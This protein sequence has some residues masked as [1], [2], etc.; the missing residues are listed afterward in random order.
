[1]LLAAGCREA[2]PPV[3]E[4]GTHSGGRSVE[5]YDIEGGAPL[6]AV[7]QSGL[8]KADA[9]LGA[10]LGIPAADRACG[11]LDLSGPRLALV[12]PDAMFYGASVP[13]LCILLGYFET[14]PEAAESL[15]PE[16]ERE[17]G[18]MIKRSSNE[19]AAK[20]SQLIGLERLQAIVQ[21][22]RHRL[23]DPER[24]GGL[25]CGKHYG[26][27]APRRGDPLR[28][29]SHAATVRQCLRFYLLLEQGRLVNPAA[30]RR[31]RE[32]F[33]SPLL[34]FHDD[35]FVAGL[36]GRDVAVLRKNGLWE[37][38]HLDTARVEHAGRVYLLAAMA[39]HPRG[40]EY[41]ARLA[42]A[43]DDLVCG[44]APPAPLRH[45]LILHESAV[46]VS[47]EFE[48]HVVEPCTPFNEV[49]VSWNAEVPRGA[50]MAVDLR[51]GR[52]C[53]G[54]WSPYLRIGGWGE[55]APRLAIEAE[56]ETEGKNPWEGGSI[57]V[58]YFRSKDAARYDRLQYRVRAWRTP[59]DSAAQESAQVR[60]VRVALST[61]DT[62]GIPLSFRP[63][64][65]E[66]AEPPPGAWQRRLEVPFR[67]QRAEDAKLAARICSPTS[68]AMVMAYRGVVRSTAEVAQ[69]AY[70]AAHD[71]FGNWPRSVQAAYS[72]GVPGYLRRFA[73]WREV[74]G[75]IAAGQPL[76]ASIRA[77]EGELRG[78]PYP[79]TSGHLLVITGF[80]A[81]GNVCV[82]DP[83]ASDA[84]AGQTVYRREDIE[85]VWLRQGGTAY[86]LLAP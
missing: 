35:A 37:D 52:R 67:S 76:I 38:W 61:S 83:A 48:S 70:D 3:D 44:P 30:S 71:I 72:F 47:A 21:S 51:V 46:D 31:M 2:P 53:D 18:L 22:D 78:A 27:D 40:R 9:E 15:D 19:I 62:T 86:V 56:E 32:V 4:A 69:R 65:S 8:E 63:E 54:S 66:E 34:E 16:V 14:H 50:G 75:A 39:H 79:K 45:E 59:V 42:A 5:A 74:R 55:A 1:M 43:V 36:K 58:D 17:L 25:W 7:L 84:A 64:L 20:Y 29:L 13:K 82:N 73:S 12:R 28:D 26:V 68:V 23:Y 77:A 57:D 10:E 6:D 85:R 49:L 41:L 33:A 60:V 80:D 81:A 11:V 24:G